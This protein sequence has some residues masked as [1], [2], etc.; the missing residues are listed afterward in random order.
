M[1]P[2]SRRWQASSADLLS[3]EGEGGEG[4]VGRAGGAAFP[5]RAMLPKFGTQADGAQVGGDVSKTRREGLLKGAAEGKGF[6]VAARRRWTMAVTGAKVIGALRNMYSSS[7]PDVN[8]GGGGGEDVGEWGGAGRGS[9]GVSRE[10][11]SAKG[12]RGNTASIRGEELSRRWRGS[13][14]SGGDSPEWS[15][16]PSK[17]PSVM[18]LDGPVKPCEEGS[19]REG[20]GSRRASGYSPVSVEKGFLRGGGDRRASAS[21]RGGGDEGSARG[22]IWRSSPVISSPVISSPVTSSPVIVHEE[23]SGGGTASGV[24]PSHEQRLRSQQRVASPNAAEG[25]LSPRVHRRRRSSITVGLHL[26]SNV[27]LEPGGGTVI[28]DETSRRGGRG[29]RPSIEGSGG[30]L[31]VGEAH[32]GMGGSSTD[33]RGA[34]T[35]AGTG[36]RPSIMGG[37]SRDH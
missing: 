8:D 32:V 28:V 12:R 36:R 3:M 7:V 2:W 37:T 24:D 4:G 5:L 10:S 23:T 33:L 19:G 25:Q 16:T 15:N 34:S 35:Q 13:V 17:R 11:V 31:R 6:G 30:M 29:R 26:V 20:G 27:P 21:S 22:G 9:L 18:P 1:S 14:V